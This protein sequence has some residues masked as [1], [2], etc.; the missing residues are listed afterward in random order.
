MLPFAL[1]F[2]ETARNVVGNGSIPPRGVNM[3]LLNFLQVRRQ[4]MQPQPL[5]RTV[6]HASVKSAQ[7]QMRKRRTFRIPN[8]LHTLALVLEKDVGLLLFFNA[9]IYCALYDVMASAPTLLQQIYGFNALEIGLCFLPI[10]VGSFLATGVSGVLMGGFTT[11][12]KATMK[13]QSY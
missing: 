1:T 8:P 10:G 12:S 2:P 3:N 11:F 4:R 13:K 6:S 9:I 7:E 5:D